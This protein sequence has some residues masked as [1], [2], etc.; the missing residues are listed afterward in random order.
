[1]IFDRFV[2]VQE[3]LLD[4]AVK[5]LSQM[6]DLRRCEIQLF[7]D[8]VNDIRKG[9]NNVSVQK[10]TITF[11]NCLSVSSSW[12]TMISGTRLMVYLCCMCVQEKEILLAMVL[13]LPM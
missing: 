5:L 10:G 8:Q 13:W 7:L 6:L 1:M 3:F 12:T 2:V 9:G 11:R 4:G